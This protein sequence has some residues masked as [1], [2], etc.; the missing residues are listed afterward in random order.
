M[1]FED[2]AK[3]NGRF[4]TRGRIIRPGEPGQTFPVRPVMRL[5]HKDAR[6]D[7]LQMLAQVRPDG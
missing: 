6:P 4:Y 7:E 1:Y 2:C 3:N 5:K